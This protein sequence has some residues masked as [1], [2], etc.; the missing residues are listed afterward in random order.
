MTHAEAVTFL[1][2]RVRAK[3][4]HG[5]SRS[6]PYPGTQEVFHTNKVHVLICKT[7]KYAVHYDWH[8]GVSCGYGKD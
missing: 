8:G 6:C 3:D 2:N 5:E 7:C 1:M 4:F